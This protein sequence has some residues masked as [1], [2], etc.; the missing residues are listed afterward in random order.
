MR[1]VNLHWQAV[2]TLAKVILGRPLTRRV[3][4]PER[5]WSMDTVERWIDGNRV[6]S[7][8]TGFRLRPVIRD[9][10]EGNFYPSVTPGAV[11]DPAPTGTEMDGP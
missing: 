4:D 11:V 10:S 8:L 2:E 1:L 7:I 6:V 3:Q 9:E 5:Q